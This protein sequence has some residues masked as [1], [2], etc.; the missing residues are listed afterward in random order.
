MLLVADK[1]SLFILSGSGDVVEPDCGIAA[2]GS[3]GNYA[4]SAARAYIEN[5]ALS[6]KDIV[7]K[8]LSI[9]ADICIYTNHSITVEEIK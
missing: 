9:A 2:I 1:N 5:P 6:A 3:G 4:L 8:S 7:K